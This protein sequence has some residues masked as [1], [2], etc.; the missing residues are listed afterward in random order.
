MIFFC[1][2]VGRDMSKMHLV[3]CQT[4]GPVVR[5]WGEKS[6]LRGVREKLRKGGRL[7]AGIAL[8]LAGVFVVLICSWIIGSRLLAPAQRP[9]I[10]RDQGTSVAFKSGS[11]AELK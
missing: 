4:N 5:L 3:W 7:R 11:G 2:A 10:L 8:V 1:P 9:V 6:M